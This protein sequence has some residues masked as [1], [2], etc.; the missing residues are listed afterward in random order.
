M[1]LSANSQAP[2]VG[3]VQARHVKEVPLDASLLKKGARNYATHRIRRKGLPTH[4]PPS[5]LAPQPSS[6]S[7]DQ[8]AVEGQ[9]PHASVK[10][11]RLAC[12]TAFMRASCVGQPIQGDQHSHH[13]IGQTKHCCDPL[14]ALL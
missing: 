11:Q 13:H 3:I 12:K 2:G 6:G 4:V 14:F 1:Y 5:W 9:V 7:V 8:H 10:L